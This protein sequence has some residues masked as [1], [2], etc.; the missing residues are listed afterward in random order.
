M[1]ERVNPVLHYH[2]DGFRI[3][4]DDLKGRHSAGESFL[5]AFLEQAEAGDVFAFC[6]REHFDEFAATVRGFR[7]DLLPQRVDRDGV[8][9]LRAQGVFHLAHP[10]IAR[11]AMVRS[12]VGDQSYAIC[13]V[14]FTISSQRALTEFSSIP[15]L[16]LQPWDALICISQPVRRSV[17][18]ILELAEQDLRERIGATQ[19]TRP[20]LPVIPLGT[21]P[22]RF[23]RTEQ[24]RRRWREKLGIDDDTIA[25]LFFGRLSFH[26]KASPLQLAQ[27]VEQAAGTGVARFAVIWCGRF[28][29]DLQRRAFLETA[30][31]MAPSVAFHHVD[32]G[33]PDVAGVWSAGDIFCSLSD[34]VQ[35]SFG[36]T[37]IEA[38]A[39]ELPVIVANWDG[40][41]EAIRHGE[42]GVLVDSYFPPVSM[43]DAAYRHFGG[44]DDYDQ[45]VGGLSQFSMIDSEQAATWFG[46]LAG[47]ADLRHR[48]GAAA[49]QTIDERYDWRVVLPR[50]HDLWR[51]Q[52]T[53][54]EHARRQAS[55]VT[56]STWKRYDPALVFASFP[57]AQ[58]GRDTLLAQGPQY[59]D[60][61]E[62]LRKPGVLANAQVLI[63]DA[64]YR[65]LHE[66]FA[67]NHTR[68]VAD[69]LATAPSA[70]RGRI[71]RAL[72]W[73]VK[74]GLLRLVRI[75]PN[76]FEV[77]D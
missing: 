60:W 43:G 32:G 4:R 28:V 10:E 59:A 31:S 42:N 3:V 11:E 12:F 45:F 70:R 16:P 39:A 41:R 13:G 47:D 72:H 35:E 33:D 55:S 38:M 40:Y 65:A 15:A 62:H 51:E 64:E 53:M 69:V 52:A 5:A 73:L 50:Y 18:A 74:V 66:L 6:G 76:V 58:M 61:A 27:A 36:L 63:N 67:D 8:A 1:N 14:T 20:M 23:R 21:H 49:R 22:Q 75:D 2:P 54:L 17:E 57:S 44:A 48:M 77:R 9:R 24:A 19:F 68:T 56:S 71:F 37:V 34:N 30:Q 25:V 7:A 29:G 26:A 46:R